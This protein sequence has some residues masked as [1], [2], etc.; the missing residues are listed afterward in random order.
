MFCVSI[1]AQGKPE[2]LTAEPEDCISLIIEMT[3]LSRDEAVGHLV[4][5]AFLGATS[6]TTTSYELAVEDVGDRS[7]PRTEYYL[8]YVSSQAGDQ[9]DDV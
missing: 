1:Y 5:A 8:P 3:G 7:G 9:E 6:V 2:C 4:N